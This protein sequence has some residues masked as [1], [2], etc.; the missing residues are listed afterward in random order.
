MV[1][2]KFFLLFFCKQS[3][4]STS[5]CGKTKGFL[6]QIEAVPW[7]LRTW[8]RSAANVHTAT[9]FHRRDTS[10]SPRE[11]NLLIH[12]SFKHE[13]IFFGHGAPNGSPYIRQWWCIILRCLWDWD[14]PAGMCSFKGIK[15]KNCILR[16]ICRET[17]ATNTVNGCAFGSS[18]KCI[19]SMRAVPPHGK[20]FLPF[21][22][23]L[24]SAMCPSL[25]DKM[26]G[27]LPL[28]RAVLLPGLTSML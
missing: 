27:F 16:W 12:E 24:F 22:S 4:K 25:H 18:F 17:Q 9:C 15:K 14:M 7:I 13:E 21:L 1:N 2:F 5:S 26:I 20:Y 6:W 19:S 28:V 3:W 8:V 10:F 11:I 23:W